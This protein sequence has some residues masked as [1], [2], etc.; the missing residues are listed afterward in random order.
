MR[1]LAKFTTPWLA[2]AY[3]RQRLF[4]WLDQR[5]ES[6]VIWVCAPPGAGKTT[7]ISSY[8][9]ARG[10]QRIW[11][12][13]DA[14]DE[15]PA[16]FF[17]YLREAAP[18]RKTPLPLLTPEYLPDLSGFTKRFFRQLFRRLP[19]PAAL[20]LDNFQDVQECG[21]LYGVVRDAGRRFRKAITYS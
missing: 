13:I 11:Y 10:L 4:E 15:D 9:S 6:R 21:H 16:T 3:P 8:V 12:Q 1:A 18:R 2:D 19:R 17:H 20:V 14:G 7:L 5:R